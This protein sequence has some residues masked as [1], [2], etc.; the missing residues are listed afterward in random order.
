VVRDRE[1]VIHVILAAT[2]VGAVSHEYPRQ[3]A[4][5]AQA[6]RYQIMR[7]IYGRALSIID[8]VA[9]ADPTERLRVSREVGF[10][11][12]REALAENGDWVMLHRELPIEMLHV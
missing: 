3:C 10:E 7:E 1:W 8:D 4:F 9:D 12:G 2:I 11:I 6:R 5:H